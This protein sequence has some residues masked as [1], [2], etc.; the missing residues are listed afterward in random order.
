MTAPSNAVSSPTMTQMASFRDLPS[1]AVQGMTA[2]SEVVSDDTASSPTMTQVAPPR[3]SSSQ[4]VSSTMMTQMTEHLVRLT[5]NLLELQR[6][7]TGCDVVLQCK[8]GVITAHSGGF[9]PC[10]S[11]PPPPSL[12]PPSDH[13]SCLLLRELQKTESGCDVTLKCSDG[14]IKAHLGGPCYCQTRKKQ[15]VA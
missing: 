9:L 5:R 8:D 7:G 15:Q 14:Y 10:F 3:D 11:S 2:P 4:A 13:I 12:L 6:A 1:E